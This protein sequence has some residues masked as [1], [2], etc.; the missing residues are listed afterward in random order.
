M[1]DPMP[2]R[3]ALADENMRGRRGG[4]GNFFHNRACIFI[5]VALFNRLVSDPAALV[6][7]FDEKGSIDV[8]AAW[9][10]T[11]PKASAPSPRCSQNQPCAIGA[12]ARRCG[13]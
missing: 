3:G 4:G 8:S 2:L 7:Q 1:A 9:S 11:I 6:E 13:A 12:A 10:T 5:A